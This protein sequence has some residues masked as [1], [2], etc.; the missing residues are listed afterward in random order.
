MYDPFEYMRRMQQEMD[1][2][3]DR[4]FSRSYRQPL[5]AS[6]SEAEAPDKPAMVREP[7]LDIVDEKDHYKVVVEVPGIDRKDLNI[8]VTEENLT[9]Q[10]QMKEEKKQEDK[11]Y[12]YQERRYGSFQRSIALP[13][14]V[15][16]EQA[17]AEC[18][19]GILEVKLKKK[20]ETKTKQHRV[21]VK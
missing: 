10:A 11:G 9:I 7:L 14:E 8:N 12:F 19:N 18:K 21:E 4:F 17:S 5:L 13:G 15:I 20:H 6:G 16:P 3:F 2:A 1:N